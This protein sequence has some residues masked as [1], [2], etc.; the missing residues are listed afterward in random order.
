MEARTIEKNPEAKKSPLSLAEKLEQLEKINT[1]LKN[2]G[3]N[4][5]IPFFFNEKNEEN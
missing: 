1:F 3:C 2:Q 4:S 5:I